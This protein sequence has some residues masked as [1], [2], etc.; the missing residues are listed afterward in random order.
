MTKVI[1]NNKTDPWKRDVNVFFTITNCQ[2]VSS[3]SLTHR[4]TYTFIFLSAYWQW[5]LAN[6]RA[7]ISVVIVKLIIIKTLNRI[8]ERRLT[9]NNFYYSRIVLIL[10]ISCSWWI[11]M[12]YCTIF[13][14]LFFKI[15]EAFNISMHCSEQNKL[16]LTLENKLHASMNK[17]N[18]Q[19]HCY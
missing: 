3:L 13:S 8:T 19:I 4:I 7:R 2:I 15:T 12:N 17:N 1:V 18:L 5:K 16:T 11:Q 6:E 10:R 14:R 9:L